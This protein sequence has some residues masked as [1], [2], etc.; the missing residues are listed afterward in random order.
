VV[1]PSE[2]GKVR[3]ESVTPLSE[4]VLRASGRDP[5]LY[6]ALALVDA[7]RVGQSR[8]RRLASEILAAR[9]TVNPDAVVKS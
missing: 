5:W 9:L 3:G 2:R 4:G 8:D 7:L 1:W 6:D